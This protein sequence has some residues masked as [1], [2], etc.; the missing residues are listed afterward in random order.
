[1]AEARA[2]E[3]RSWPVDWQPVEGDSDG[4]FS[5]L[6]TLAVRGALAGAIRLPEGARAA[7]LSGLARLAMC[8]ER[9]R[10]RAAHDF[11]RQALGELEPADLARRTCAAYAQLFQVTLDTE[12]FFAEV[13]LARVLE[14]VELVVSPA[15]RA[16][17]DSKRGCLVVGA[18]LGNWEIGL[19]ALVASGWHPVYGVAKP[20]RNRSLSRLL[21][22]SRERHGVRILSRKGSMAAAPA[23]L[24]AGGVIGMILDQRTSGRALLAPFFGRLARCE[25]APGVLLKRQ[26]VPI[27]M[28]TCLMAERS[29]HFRLEL[30]TV[31]DPAQWGARPVEEIVA[32]INQEFERTI[33]AHPEQYVWI[34]DRYRD[35]PRALEAGA[36]PRMARGATAANE[37]GQEE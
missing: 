20:P 30:G 24:K 14:H 26:R 17:F 3:S 34:H 7:L 13:P 8:I 1:M 10:V 28:A 19:T 16:V 9:R 2:D 15:A 31:L 25:R 27:V 18:H 12:R 37:G 29:L 6:A 4:F 22:A 35:T 32:R 23:V 21:Q 33:R 5:R 11:L 36:A